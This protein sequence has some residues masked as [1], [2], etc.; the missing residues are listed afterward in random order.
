L[1]VFQCP[2]F[3]WTQRRVT[4]IISLFPDPKMGP[5]RLSTRSSQLFSWLLLL[6]LDFRE[7]C[8]SSDSTVSPAPKRVSRHLMGWAFFGF[9]SMDERHR[10]NTPSI[11]V[12]L[13]KIPRPNSLVGQTNARVAE[14]PAASQAAGYLISGR[15]YDRIQR[16]A[17]MKPP[18][19][20]SSREE[21]SVLP[22]PSGHQPPPDHTI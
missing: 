2:D 22:G 17:N 10:S 7:I 4:S 14:G 16:E 13:P 18:Q 3:F 21:V 6:Q 20:D 19:S 11:A 12:V 5:L 15:D 9:S 8:R 1:V